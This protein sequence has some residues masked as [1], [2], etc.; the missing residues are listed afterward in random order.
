[1]RYWMIFQVIL[2]IWL[3]V[4]PIVLGF[5]EIASMS[6]N[7]VIVGTI[8]MILGLVFAFTPL[9]AIRHPEKKTF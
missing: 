1:M 9:P 5:R 7:N 4:S 3:V 8:V 6:M 2:G